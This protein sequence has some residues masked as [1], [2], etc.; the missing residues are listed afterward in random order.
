MHPLSSDDFVLVMLKDPSFF[1]FSSYPNWR[2]DYAIFN[3]LQNPTTPPA[4]N[5]FTGMLCDFV[6]NVHQTI[7]KLVVRPRWVRNIHS[8][9][10]KSPY[11]QKW[12]KPDYSPGL[13]LAF[14]RNLRSECLQ[15][16]VQHR[17]LLHHRRP[18]PLQQIWRCRH[19]SQGHQQ[20]PVQHA[21]C[22]PAYFAKMDL[23]ELWVAVTFIS[24]TW[25]W[26]P[27]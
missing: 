1:S 16:F 19:T 27:V 9:S 7:H 14:R 17:W 12:T 3:N 10:E 5:L 18:K 2:P 8:Q 22:V 13:A 23:D 6:F 26:K 25:Y 21:P 15:F 20:R 11:Q 24:V 4:W